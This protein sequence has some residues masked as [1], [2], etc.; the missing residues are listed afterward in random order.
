M[1]EQSINSKKSNEIFVKKSPATDM[2]SLASALKEILIQ[3]Q[4][5]TMIR[6]GEKIYETL[7]NSEE[8]IR[9][10][11]APGYFVIKKSN[12]NSQKKLLKEYNS[13]NTK[14]LTM[15]DLII[16]LKSLLLKNFYKIELIN[17]V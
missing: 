14:K 15:K 11:N 8:M 2:Y 1:V 12:N 9:T 10:I 6:P 16:L 7:I 4:N 13:N 17:D 5:L 3:N